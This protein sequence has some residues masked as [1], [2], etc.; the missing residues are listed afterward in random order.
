MLLMIILIFF[1]PLNFKWLIHK[2][3]IFSFEKVKMTLRNIDDFNS[4]SKTMIIT[5]N[6]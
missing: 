4:K 2:N 5:H 1:D 6:F 3:F